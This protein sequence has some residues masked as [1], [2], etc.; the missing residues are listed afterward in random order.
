MTFSIHIDEPTA[1]ALARAVRE[2]GK[3]RN[4]LIRDAIRQWLAS[5]ERREWP[6]AVRDFRGE[7]RVARFEDHRADLREPLDPFAASARRWRRP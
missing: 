3:T 4:R 6:A 2:S 5:A 7:G 1:E